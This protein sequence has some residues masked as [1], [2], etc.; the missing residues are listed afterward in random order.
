MK[1]AASPVSLKVDVSRLPA[2]GV[3][4]KLEA[5]AAQRAAL[6]GKHGLAAVRAFSLEL[7]FSPW[8]RDG[9][10]VEGS[11]KA[12]ITQSCIVSLD[13]VDA[14]IDEAVSAI[15]VPENS[16]LDPQIE[17]GEILLDAEGED[18]PDTFS[19]NRIDAG[20]LAEEFFA[21]AIDPYPRRK[22]A[23]LPENAGNNDPEETAEAP[24][25]KLGAL[26]RKS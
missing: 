11:V 15:L 24:F 12:N 17:D 20:T 19:G 25:A 22:D 21:L 6:A 3:V 7:C 14:A 5:D 8:K 4:V 16:R 10:R 18:A 1:P 23:E 26:V 13:P 9:V 2:K